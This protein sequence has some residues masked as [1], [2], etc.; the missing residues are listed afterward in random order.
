[1]RLNFTDMLYALSS[2]LDAVEKE[3][4]N[5]LDGHGK[6]V[7]WMSEKMGQAA[8]MNA[9]QLIDLTGLALL[10][11][12]AIVKYLDSSVNSYVDK[13][14]ENEKSLYQKT[15]SFRGH[16]QTGEEWVEMLPFNTK[17]E[18]I[19]LYHH[20]RADGHG[21]FGIPADQ[22]PLMA[23]LIHL[24]DSIDVTFHLDDIKAVNHEKIS[25]YVH[26]E[27]RKA[28]TKKAVNLYDQSFSMSCIHHVEQYG[29]DAELKADIP[30][31][32]RQFDWPEIRRITGFFAGI[33]DDKSSFTKSHSLG[34]ARRAEIMARHYGWDE[35]KVQRYYVAGAFHDIGKLIISNDILEKPGRLTSDEFEIMQNHASQTY[36]ILH[37]IHGFEDITEWASNHHEKLDGSG[38]PRGL[39]ADQLSFEDRLMACIDIYQALTEERPYKKG[40]SHEKTMAIMYDMVS[41]GKIDAGITNDIDQI[42]RSEQKKESINEQK[43]SSQSASTKRWKCPI[44]GY[45][46]EGENP[47]ERCPVCDMP[48]TGYQLIEE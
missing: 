8:G 44:C 30:D 40:L 23:Q 36:R 15:D 12:N 21:A 1:M 47:P 2:A 35:D 20:E 31:N 32:F 7:A 39:S 18:N 37:Q 4:Q 19:I 43:D 9:Q 27:E 46:Y 10:H 14:A 24:A 34:V 42:F 6:R 11:D 25:N 17:P 5:V 41:Q 33:V 38:Y 3:Y 26:A 22:I 16:C 29:V 28:F 45:V 13:G 48:G